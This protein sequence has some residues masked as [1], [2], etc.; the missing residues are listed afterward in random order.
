MLNITPDNV[1]QVLD[2]N[3]LVLLDFS[4]EWCSPCKIMQPEL[5]ELDQEADFVVAK[6]DIDQNDSLVGKL[7][8]TNVPTLVFFR[9]GKEVKRS[10]GLS[11]KREL[12][13]MANALLRR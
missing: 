10:I 6:V 12:L 8:I 9:E 5:E 2:S 11:S 4:A 1:Q 3:S 7:R 13:E